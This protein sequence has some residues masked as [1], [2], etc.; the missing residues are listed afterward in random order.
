MADGSTPQTEDGAGEEAG[1]ESTEAELR[2]E[3]EEQKEGLDEDE[4]S[5]N[6]NDPSGIKDNLNQYYI[7]IKFRFSN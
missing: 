7:S 4:N 3:G 1:P 6:G 2:K 5:S